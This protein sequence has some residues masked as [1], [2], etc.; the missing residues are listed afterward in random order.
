MKIT[1]SNDRYQMLVVLG[2][3]RGAV[4][5]LVF[6]AKI[7]NEVSRFAIWIILKSLDHCAYPIISGKFMF[8]A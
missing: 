4:I 1:N 8:V 2:Y 3:L 6:E 5:R 7:K